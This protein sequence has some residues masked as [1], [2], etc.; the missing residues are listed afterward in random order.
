MFDLKIR[1]KLL[2]K[3]ELDFLSI[4]FVLIIRDGFDVVR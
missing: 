2:I 4:Q 1:S 3:K